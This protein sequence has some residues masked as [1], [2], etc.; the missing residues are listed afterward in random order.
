M[1]ASKRIGSRA[2]ENGL[3][4]DEELDPLN[5]MFLYDSR[6]RRTESGIWFTLIILT[7]S[8]HTHFFFYCQADMS[9][10]CHSETLLVSLDPHNFVFHSKMLIH[11]SAN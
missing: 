7:L 9:V 10:E 3:V 11:S 8:E 5:S 2:R 4:S 1:R 6:R